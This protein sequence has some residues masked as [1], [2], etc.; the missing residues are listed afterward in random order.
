MTPEL[1]LDTQQKIKQSL[2]EALKYEDYIINQTLEYTFDSSILFNNYTMSNFVI[3]DNSYSFKISGFDS[4]D[5]ETFANSLV[6]NINN[7]LSFDTLSIIYRPDSN[8][9]TAIEPNYKVVIV[10]LDNPSENVENDNEAIPKI[11]LTDRILNYIEKV[12]EREV[13]YLNPMN[14]FEK[15]VCMFVQGMIFEK[16][17]RTEFS[18]MINTAE[19]SIVFYMSSL[20]IISIDDIK[21]SVCECCGMEKFSI[22][23]RVKQLV[24]KAMNGDYLIK[25][26]N[27]YY[28]LRSKFVH[29]GEFLSSNNYIGISIPILGYR[30]LI[31]QYPFTN[32]LY[33]EFIKDCIIFHEVEIY[34]E[35]NADY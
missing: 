16:M 18:K 28:N 24:E 22:A 19:Q 17:S 20:E 34:G 11:E 29:T 3:N 2:K 31:S 33:K 8:V 26:I 15:A 1:E 35:L 9:K 6:Y 27:N 12:I 13:N 4:I 10:N 5:I 30:R 23:K 21:S 25:E 14:R 32:H 7:L